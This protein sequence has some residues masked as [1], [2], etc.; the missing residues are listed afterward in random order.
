MPFIQRALGKKVEIVPILIGMPGPDSLAALSAGIARILRDDPHAVLV[1]SSDLSHFNDQTAALA[2]DNRVIDAM[3]RLSTRELELYLKSGRGEM[4]GGW[5]TVYG[6]SA[7]RAAGA[8][9]AVRYRS[10]TS[11]D[12]NGDRKS[13]VG[14]VAMGVMQSRLSEKQ[15]RQLHDLAAT[16]VTRH[17][18]G[19]QVPSAASADPLF[20][21][22]GATFV[23]LNDAGGRLRGCIGTIQPQMS[24][25]GSVI[26][27]AVSAASHDNRFP[28]VRADELASLRVEVTILSPLEA[29]NDSASIVVGRHGV[30]LEKEGRSSVFLPQVPLE[31]GWDLTTYLSQL[32]LKA[33]LPPDGWKGARLSVFTAEVVR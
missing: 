1:I 16:T 3:E 27:N 32:A 20:K 4:C 28:P 14:Y 11:A 25:Y 31:Q 30:Y 10:G 5:P 9:H 23:T 22:D 12:V 15:K 13:V 18:K 21:A 19:Q 2:K 33:G 29:V 6:I 7:A 24:L 26:S 17:V 8:T